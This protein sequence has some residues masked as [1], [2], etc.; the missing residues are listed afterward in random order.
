M[1]HHRL[2]TAILLL[3]CG[4]SFAQ[5]PLLDTGAQSLLAEAA[6]AFQGRRYTEAEA[7][8][9]QVVEKYPGDPARR[10]AWLGLA[11]CHLRGFRFEQV[12]E[13]IGKL[14]ADYPEDPATQQ[15]QALKALVQ[16]LRG[17]FAAAEATWRASVEKY[18]A[19]DE[20]TTLRQMGGMDWRKFDAGPFL[21]ACREYLKRSDAVPQLY[22]AAAIAFWH[23]R[24]EMGGQWAELI[25]TLE[26]VQPRLPTSGEILN[27]LG[28]AYSHAG[29][30]AKAVQVTEQRLGAVAA[31]TQDWWRLKYNVG[32]LWLLAGEHGK[33]KTALEEVAGKLPATQALHRWA[34]LDLAETARK[35]GRPAEARELWGK[36]LAGAKGASDT[37]TVLERMAQSWTAEGNDEQAL[38]TYQRMKEATAAL[39]REYHAP[40]AAD[41]GIASC[42]AKL[43]RGEEAEA[44]YRALLKDAAGDAHLWHRERATLELGKLLLATGKEAEG[45]ELL[46]ELAKRGVTPARREAAEGLGSPRS[47]EDHGE[48]RERGDAEAPSRRAK[49]KAHG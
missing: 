19:L 43:G 3:K 32:H 33:A 48:G 49:D 11:R 1:R 47:R 17:D 44:A 40:W 35:T 4:L 27:L 22:E 24:G 8:Y 5:L 25:E 21:K 42:L 26:R 7:V 36:L 9:R 38:A 45:R 15:G 34:L 12:V 13:S 28:E 30:Y 29:Q 10:Q 2:F 14:E 46:A 20:S 31:D 16:A 37:C 41:F 6:K 23:A 39:G 18:P